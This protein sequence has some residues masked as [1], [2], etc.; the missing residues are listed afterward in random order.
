MNEPTQG[1]VAEVILQRYFIAMNTGDAEAALGLFTED[2]I[3]LDTAVPELIKV[4]KAQIAPGL[5]ARV[6]DHIQIE[7][8]EYQGEKNHA[9]CMAAVST[10]YGRRLGFA[11]V[12][13]KAEIFVELGKIKQFIV[14]VSPES[15][16]RIKAAEQ[17]QAK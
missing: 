14:T 15:L 17:Q 10:D 6:A 8:S 7:T 3:R 5:W 13:E 2:A 12:I 9:Q 16:E 1:E 4:G 11:P